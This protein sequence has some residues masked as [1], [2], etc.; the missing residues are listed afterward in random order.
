MTTWHRST[1]LA[2]VWPICLAAGTWGYIA[3]SLPAR[4]I[5]RVSPIP[6]TLMGS[7]IGLLLVFR[8]TNTYQRLGEARILWG[9]AVRARAIE[10]QQQQQQWPIMIECP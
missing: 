2:A 3:G 6:M 4:L 8:T 5:D 1:V 7:A 9:R 10:P